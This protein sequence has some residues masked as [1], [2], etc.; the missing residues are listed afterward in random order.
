[1]I[2]LLGEVTEQL[3]RKLQIER[4]EFTS[5]L[6]NPE[7]IEVIVVRGVIPI[8]QHLMNQ[9][10]NLKL[11]I[12]AGIGIDNID[13][14]YTQEK[15]ILVAN[16]PT[17]STISTAEHAF[18]HLISA[19]RQIPKVTTEMKNFTWDRRNNVNHEFH[20]KNVGIVGLGRIGS[21]FAKLC[22]GVG[23]QVYAYDAYI[24]DEQ[25]T[26]VNAEKVESLEKLFSQVNYVS[27]HVPKLSETTNLVREE[28][29][30][31]LLKP[32]GIVN[33]SRGGVIS[34]DLTYRMLNEG[35]LDFYAVD[36][37]ESEPELSKELLQHPKVQATPHIGA[38]TYEAQDRIADM[39]VQQI[40]EF[41]HEGSEPKFIVK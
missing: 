16:C 17:G 13:L 22:N 35:V 18:T 4:F 2:Y 40:R 31:S 14:V 12:S 11:V 25:F 32:N 39:V 38:N 23:M 36:V 27:L 19:I 1:M 15:S 5:E 9:L 34:E 28:H 29:I 41:L 26:A 10:P 24:S 6:S 8:D 33:T 37:F 20:Q 7:K 3:Q 30:R 21:H